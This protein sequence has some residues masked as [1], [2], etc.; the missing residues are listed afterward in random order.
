MAWYSGVTDAIGG[1]TGGILGTTKKPSTNNPYTP[2]TRQEVG[3]FA[4]AIQDPNMTDAQKRQSVEKAAIGAGR[5]LID[6]EAWNDPYFGLN[7]DRYQQQR[8][9]YQDFGGELMGRQRDTIDLLDSAARGAQP[10]A[11]QMMMNQGLQ[12]AQAQQIGAASA[13]RG[14][15][16]GLALRN[17]LGAGSDLAGQTVGQAGVLRAQEMQQARQ[18]LSSALAN[19]GQL[20]GAQTQFYEQMGYGAQQA[21]MAARRDLETYLANREVEL[22]RIQSGIGQAA[23]AAQAQKQA[24][25]LGAG[26]T[27]GAAAFMAPAAAKPGGALGA[28]TASNPFGSIG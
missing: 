15:S 2:M 8:Q 3:S 25:M 23:A 19:Y 4:S 27:I 1:V 16:R 21:Q 13:A 28:G 6:E 5:Y 24:A 20:A 12:S 11:A 14:G 9:Q 10:S 22:K 7:N 17:A 26:A 18:D